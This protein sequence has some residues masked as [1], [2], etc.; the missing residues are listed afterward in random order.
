MPRGGGRIYLPLSVRSSVRPDTD[1]W[2]D[3]LSPPT[4]LELQL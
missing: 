2:F 1:T 3:R 4:V